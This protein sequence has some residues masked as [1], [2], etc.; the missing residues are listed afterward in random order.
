MVPVDIAGVILADSFILL[1]RQDGLE[2]DETGEMIYCPYTF[3]DPKAKQITSN[4]IN[5]R[6]IACTPPPRQLLVSLYVFSCPCITDLINFD[7]F[8]KRSIAVINRGTPCTG[9]RKLLFVFRFECSG[10]N[11]NNGFAYGSTLVGKNRLH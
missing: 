2:L 4:E 8:I 1:L 6:A 11:K 9:S 7:G 5:F 3:I 10:Y